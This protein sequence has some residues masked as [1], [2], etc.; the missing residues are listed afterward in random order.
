MKYL[1]LLILTSYLF[2]SCGGPTAFTQGDYVD[3][4]KV[5]LLD[6]TFN[7]AD[8]QKIAK[9][10]VESL[11]KSSVV[12]G[13]RPVIFLEK[14][15]NATHEHIDMTSLTSMIRTEL[16]K[17]GRV[18]FHNKKHR[19]TLREEYKYQND[20]G[21]VNKK[22]A[23]KRGFQVGS[24][25]ILAGHFSSHVQELGR[26]EVIYYKLT[27]NLTNISTG[28]IDWSDEKQIKKVFKKHRYAL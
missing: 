10:V 21:I 28:L 16:L 17:T 12:Q 27:L 11:T 20:T 23:K 2:S 14:V 4:N 8:M 6:D 7:E 5:I 3:P 15:E 19:N 9:A 1:Y 13:R 24:D 25:Y 22:T 18:S 26:M